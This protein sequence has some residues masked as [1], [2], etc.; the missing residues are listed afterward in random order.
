[1]IKKIT[2]MKVYNFVDSDRTIEMKC[3]QNCEKRK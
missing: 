1:M 2:T 3:C